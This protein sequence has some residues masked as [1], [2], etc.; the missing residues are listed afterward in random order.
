MN[1]PFKAVLPGW[2][3][4]IGFSCMTILLAAAF[5]LLWT[6]NLNVRYTADHGGVTPIWHHWLPALIGLFLIRVIPY[7]IQ[8]PSPFRQMERRHL[9]VQ[10][11][12]LVI[13]GIVFAAS[14][15]TLDHQGSHFE[16]YYLAIKLTTLLG[17]PLVFLLIYSK[18]TGAEREIFPIEPG[19]RKQVIVPLIILLVWGYL[20]FYSPFA[21]QEGAV[22]A[23]DLT[24][25]L[26]LVAIGFL[27]NSVLEEVF[28]RIWLQT[29]L[30]ALLGRWPAILL[31]SIL[32]SVW[33][34]AIQG[35]GQWDVDAA[36]VI[37]NHGVTGL[38]LGYVWA[39]YRK[40]WAIILIHGLL[41]ASPHMLTQLLFH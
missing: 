20:K 35:S 14:L 4:A 12:V 30:E 8:N 11:L 31:V 39:R 17:I 2:G 29:R 37:A 40:G 18:R 36:S 21:Q 24:E 15:V 28:Y 34:V 10:S 13:S 1:Q 23:A 32:W 5:W 25:F 19:S 38:F 33:H 9:V 41:N 6:G 7:S 3:R 27:I 26:L 22:E 16:T